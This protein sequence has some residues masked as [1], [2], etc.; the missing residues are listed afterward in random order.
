MLFV[1]VKREAEAV[2]NLRDII[3][4]LNKITNEPV[5]SVTISRPLAALYIH[6]EHL[7]TRRRSTNRLPMEAERNSRNSSSRER[8][9]PR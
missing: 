1:K 6:R 5:V 4:E 2:H 9:D 7:E 8:A 3:N